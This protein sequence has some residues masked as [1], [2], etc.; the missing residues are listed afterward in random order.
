MKVKTL[1]ETPK[2]LNDPAD[3]IDLIN[4]LFASLHTW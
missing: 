3:L 4:N 1:L 2:T